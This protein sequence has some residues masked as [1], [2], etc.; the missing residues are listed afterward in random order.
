MPI[1]PAPSAST[2]FNDLKAKAAQAGAAAKGAAQKAGDAA[3]AAALEA[4]IAMLKQQIKSVQQEL[5]VAI[6]PYLEEMKAD[7]IKAAYA[8]AKARIQELEQQILSKTGEIAKLKS[9]S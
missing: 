9:P 4:E 2:M 5:G 1:P 3:K 6:Y 8:P 7:E